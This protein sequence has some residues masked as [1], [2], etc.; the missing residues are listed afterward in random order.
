MNDR[1][2]LHGIA[3]DGP[4]RAEHERIVRNAL[5]RGDAVPEALTAIDA[6]TYGD[7]VVELARRNW[8][9]A[10]I[11][12]HRSSTVFSQLLP[13]LIEAG[14][15]LDWKTTVLRMALDELHHAELCGRVV[16]ALG[17]EP[18]TPAPLVSAPLPKHAKVSPLERV[19][20]YVLHASCLSETV[21]VS[22]TTD[23][24]ERTADP[25]IGSVTRALASDEILHARF[26]WAFLAEVWPELDAAARARTTSYLEVAFHHLEDAYYTKPS[27]VH[28]PEAQHAPL[29]ALGVIEPQ[30]MAALVHD[31]IHESIVPALETHGIDARGAWQRRRAR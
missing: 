2:Q 24:R 9:A 23:M 15:T 4:M 10:M 8:I 31:T 11:A 1:S 12:E 14:A 25:A 5:R 28:L 29:A 13:D 20:R 18:S 27:Q 7:D 3:G 22:L 19:L 17:G 6:K 16:V 30:R 26:G 21:S